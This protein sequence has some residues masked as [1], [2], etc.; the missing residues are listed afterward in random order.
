VRA[1]EEEGVAP[2]VTSVSQDAAPVEWKCALQ[3]SSPGYSPQPDPRT[4]RSAGGNS[5]A[6][7]AIL[8]LMP[9]GDGGVALATS[10]TGDCIGN[11]ALDLRTTGQDAGLRGEALAVIGRYTLVR[12]GPA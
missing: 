8:A 4:Y 7:D 10:T 1:G 6:V 3:V 9:Q 12:N 11:V 2:N 5:A